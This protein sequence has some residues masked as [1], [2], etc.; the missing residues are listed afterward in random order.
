MRD[1]HWELFHWT[2]EHR[3]EAGEFRS[4]NVPVPWM[5]QLVGAGKARTIRLRQIRSGSV[6]NRAHIMCRHFRRRLAK[7]LDPDVALDEI[8]DAVAELFVETLRLQPFAVGS[9][10]IALLNMHV[11]YKFAGCAPV[12]LSEHDP[13][14]DDAT[15]R[16]LLPGKGRD[17]KNNRSALVALM[18]RRH[19][20]NTG[21]SA[22]DGG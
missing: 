15:A 18:L 8:V 17:A 14:V 20:D 12:I 7:P 5:L 13:A 9:Y 6:H 10:E 21:G 1:W 22:V 4:K 3:A 19:R 16:A 11:G 2:T